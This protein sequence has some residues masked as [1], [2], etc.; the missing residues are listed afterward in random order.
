MDETTMTAGPAFRN[1][2]FEDQRLAVLPRPLVEAALARPGTRQLTVTDAGYFPRARGHRRVREHG[3]RETIFILCVAG[4]GTVV[5]DG[6]SHDP[7]G[8]D[9][10][11]DSGEH[12]PL[13]RSIGCGPMDDLVAPRAG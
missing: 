5:I 1:D 4:S 3:A 13:L 8:L 11:G 10:D 2:G 6:E 12:T 7:D 9:L